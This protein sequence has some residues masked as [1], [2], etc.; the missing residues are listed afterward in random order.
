V[1]P[2]AIYPETIHGVGNSG[3]FWEGDDLGEYFYQL[4]G[5]GEFE[6]RFNT[7]VI[8]RFPILRDQARIVTDVA[9]EDLPD[10]KIALMKQQTNIDVPAGFPL[11]EKGLHVVPVQIGAQVLHLVLLHTVSPAFDPINPYRNYDELR[12]LKLFLD[13]QLPGVEPLPPEAKFIVIGDLNADPDDGDGLSGA[14]QQ[15]LEHPSLVAWMPEG[16][17]TKGNNGKYN[18]YLSGCGNDDGMIPPDPTL[19]FQMQ[20]D[21]MLPSSTV[22]QPLGGEIF[23]PDFETDK[24]AYDLACNASDHRLL[25]MELE[26]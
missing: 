24:D 2:E 3:F 23:F 12:G 11:F 7:A 9:W 19:K 13:G 8:S 14:I 6:G 15:V 20:L 4:R 16:A 25:S 22:G 1:H 26:L 5:W 10:N 18:T 21:Y 17:G